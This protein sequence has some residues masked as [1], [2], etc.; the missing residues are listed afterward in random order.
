VVEVRFDVFS[1][2]GS[3]VDA[4]LL[5]VA[6]ELVH[7]RSST[8]TGGMHL[9]I[10]LTGFDALYRALHHICPAVEPNQL[11]VCE[12]ARARDPWERQ[13]LYQIRSGRGTT[14]TIPPTLQPRIAF[15][16]MAQNLLRGIALSLT[17]PT[18]EGRGVSHDK[19]FARAA[20]QREA[21][22]LPVW[23]RLAGPG[24]AQHDF[25]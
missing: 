24:G 14:T 21:T 25:F 17:V 18:Q 13:D 8:P 3:Q 6:E 19:V 23:I 10:T 1:F 7:L 20:K 5:K 22:A 9:A 4:A 16:N 11:P 2:D 12:S 15:A